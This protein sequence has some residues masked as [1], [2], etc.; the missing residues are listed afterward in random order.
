MDDHFAELHFRLGR[1]FLAAGDTAQ[2]GEHFR[3]ARDWD[4]LQ[5]RAD[6]SINAITRRVAA[7]CQTL[8]VRLVDVDR[9]F[10]ENPL[11][12]GGIPGHEFFGDHVHL[13]V[14]GND[15]VAR[16]VYPTAIEALGLGP[17]GG[18]VTPPLSP[19]ECAEAIGCTLYDELRIASAMIQLTSGP[20]FLDQLD[21]ARRQ[22]A[23]QA[24][25]RDRLATFTPRDAELCLSIQ[26]AA[27][28]RDPQ[29]WAVR[30][31]RASLCQDMGRYTEATEQFTRLVEAYPRT[32]RFRMAL[33]GCLLK[34]GDKPAALAQLTE[35]LRLDTAN[36][37]TRRA[38]A[39]VQ[40][41]GR[42]AQ[43]APPPGNR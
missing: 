1:C 29:C 22:A 7:A 23:A 5:F 42:G 43:E 21:H 4:A 35:A 24:A 13:R 30:F 20:P 39:Q 38:L 36:Q 31:L 33:A 28:E 40:A 17:K 27:I 16:A 15:A 2:A 34:S 10:A 3:L 12:Q 14:A 11:S 25:L 26:Q 32:I 18:P 41:Y 9:A 6:S 8:G 19:R 37:E